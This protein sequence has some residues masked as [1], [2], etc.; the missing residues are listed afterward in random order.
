MLLFAVADF[1]REDEPSRCCEFNDG[2]NGPL[3]SDIPELKLG[4]QC[5]GIAAETTAAIF[6]WNA[7]NATIFPVQR[8]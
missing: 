5:T 1:I 7:V 3:F 2:E 4:Q 8:L 6:R